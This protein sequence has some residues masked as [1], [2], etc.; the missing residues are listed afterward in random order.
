MRRRGFLA[1]FF[2]AAPVVMF[3][4]A[5]VPARLAATGALV[6]AHAPQPPLSLILTLNGIV[7]QAG[8]DFIVKGNLLSLPITATDA[9]QA[10]Y[11]YLG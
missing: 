2:Q 8:K 11:R 7:Q 9:V 6:L 5:E 10:W 4:D 1:A 3:A